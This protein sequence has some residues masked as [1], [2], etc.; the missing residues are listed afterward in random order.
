MISLE[1]AACLAVSAA[2]TLV[3][4][5]TASF[6]GVV[7]AFCVLR[8]CVHLWAVRNRRTI[9]TEGLV[10]IRNG[11]QVAGDDL[12]GHTEAT[13][14]IAQHLNDKTWLADVTSVGL[15]VRGIDDERAVW[16]GMLLVSGTNEL[17]GPISVM[18]DITMLDRATLLA[19]EVITRYH[20]DE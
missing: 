6:V 7:F 11:G 4:K 13:R 10:K 19:G 1:L 14:A 9:P 15:L 12:I 5:G 17:D 2:L 16:D 18:L 8:C 20:N 3:T